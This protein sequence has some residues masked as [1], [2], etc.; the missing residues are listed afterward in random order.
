MRR[1]DT[2]GTFGRTAGDALG[3]DE[4]RAMYQALVEQIPAVLY[5][6]QPDIDTTTDFV[7]PQTLSIL[8]LPEEA[9]YTGEWSMRVHPE[10]RARMEANYE[11]MLRSADVGVDE[12]R[13]VRPDGKEIWIHDRVTILRDETGAPTLVQGVMF[14]VTDRREVEALLRERAQ[15]L[16]KVDAI[17]RRFNDL[18]LSGSGLRQVLE[19]L[20]GIVNNPVVF[21]DP[22][23]QVIELAP[24]ALTVTELLDLAEPHLREQHGQ[25]GQERAEVACALISVRV[26]D[27]EWGRIHILGV[28]SEIDDLDR[29]AL[30]RAAA[31]AGLLML[32][33]RDTALLAD[34]A[35][36][37]L[38]ADVWQGRW[39][40][41]REVIARARS[42]GANLSD[43]Q[44][45]ALVIEAREVSAGLSPYDN[46]LTRRRVME[47][48]L[49]STRSALADVGATGLCAL[50]GDLCIAIL[51]LSGSVVARSKVE[52]VTEHV[53]AGV[54]EHLPDLMVVV[55]ASR[56]C[57]AEGLRR[58]L[59]EASEAAAH[60]LRVER[61]A[62]LHHVDDLGLR[63]LLGILGEG[64]ELSRF[65]ES[66]VGPLLGA[67]AG[68]RADLLPTLRA[69][70][71]HGCHKVRTAAALHIERR[72]LYYRLDRI[73]ALL[74][75]RLGDPS[76]RLRIE[77]ALQG[78]DVLQQRSAAS[79]VGGTRD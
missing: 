39:R 76:A 7:S 64:P 67:E 35:R 48:V 34:T 30:D 23:H 51:G 43:A 16:E 14:D 59:T 56:P 63:Q 45:V 65:V 61:R 50:V 4:L 42:L 32:S 69:Y 38:I 12:Y 6:N 20:A 70:L 40:S 10:D 52:L 62:G 19:T 31:A 75:R 53:L 57:E 5:I 27:D 25:P 24:S 79:R 28:E 21:D 66:E 8:Q 55:G 68:G 46:A 49:E 26:R 13:F 58:G 9:W 3:A 41:A 17:S 78:L 71:D 1:L 29:L 54:A 37:D 36:S 33:G 60:G 15:R 72:T 73:E 11:E 44:L 47:T 22:A 18:V 74:G 2:T 77:V